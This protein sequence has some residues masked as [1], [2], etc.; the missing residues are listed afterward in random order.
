MKGALIPEVKYKRGAQASRVVYNIAIE[1]NKSSIHNCLLYS[2]E[3][4]DFTLRC[5]G[6]GRHCTLALKEMN[7]LFD[8][9][10]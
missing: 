1:Q 2:I 4:V 5:F 8:V 3:C 6:V 9:S 10:I 7:C